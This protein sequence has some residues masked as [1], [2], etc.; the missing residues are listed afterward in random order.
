MNIVLRNTCQIKYKNNNKLLFMLSRKQE[1]LFSSSLSSAEE[2]KMS[3][4]HGCVATY[5]GHVIATGCNTR[6][7]Y[8]SN[9]YF[10]QE[11]QC[12]CHAEMTVLRKIYHRNNR[13][14]YKLN[15][16]MKRLTLYIS[17][18]TNTGE[19]TNSAPCS[20]CLQMIQSYGVR[21]IVFCMDHHYFKF[22]PM[23]YNTTH[24]TWGEQTVQ[25]KIKASSYK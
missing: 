8:S 13:K 24:E 1:Q 18:R 15:R 12:S 7:S 11:N 9:D 19:S 5:G 23:D 20:N 3:F 4:K 10:I 2:S 21:K 22:N 16:I 14:K 25:K 6:K 17:R